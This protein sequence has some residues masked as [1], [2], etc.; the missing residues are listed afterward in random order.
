VG[1]KTLALESAIKERI[2]N[3]L[4]FSSN[5]ALPRQPKDQSIFSFTRGASLM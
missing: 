4:E 1:A 2:S 5:E 3:F